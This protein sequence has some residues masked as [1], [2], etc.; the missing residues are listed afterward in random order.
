MFV[1]GVEPKT[2][3]QESSIIIM[4]VIA[5]VAMPIPEP[6]AELLLG[7][8]AFCSW[9]SGAGNQRRLHDKNNSYFGF[10]FSELTYA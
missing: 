9:A 5:P 2:V 10:G 4:F 7:W 1:K 3:G 6:S 8:A